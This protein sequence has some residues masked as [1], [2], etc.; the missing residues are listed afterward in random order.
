MCIFWTSGGILNSSQIIS[1]AS[2]HRLDMWLRQTPRGAGVWE[3]NVFRA[4]DSSAG[5]LIVCDD[6]GGDFLTCA[7]RCR[8]VLVVTEP[9]GMRAYSR[10]FLAQF[11]LI[12]SPYSMDGGQTAVRVTQTGL[13]WFY[14]LRFER[15]GL[16]IDRSFEDLQI[17]RPNPKDNRLSVVCSTKSNLP[18]HRERLKFVM[19]LK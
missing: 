18:R 1:L 12:L 10:D 14:G 17:V 6:L 11:G 15:D 19:A 5:T 7:P 9:P 3:G 4:H 8:R 16:L 2:A 13:P